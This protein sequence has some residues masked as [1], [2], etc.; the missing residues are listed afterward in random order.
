MGELADLIIDFWRA[1]S[2]IYPEAFEEP[3]TYTL[4]GIPGIFSLH[5]L[6]PSVY[7]RCARSGVINEDGMR[8]VLGLLL[9]ETPGHPEPDFRR[10]INMDFWSKE[11]GPLIA[12]SMDRQFIDD[13]YRNLQLKIQLA[14][15]G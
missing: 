7:A 10:P 5:M 6:F 1:V 15:S 8:E 14:E 3:R 9:T 13:L 4:L 12:I 2:R 11:Q